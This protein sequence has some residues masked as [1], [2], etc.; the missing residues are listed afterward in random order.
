MGCSVI[1]TASGPDFPRQGGGPRGGM[2]GFGCHYLDLLLFVALVVGA[3]TAPAVASR[4]AHSSSSMSLFNAANCV[5]CP[6]NA[7]ALVV[8]TSVTMSAMALPIFGR[9]ST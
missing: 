5:I 1:A 2:N 4:F 3:T 7:R 9:P 6:R 8:Q